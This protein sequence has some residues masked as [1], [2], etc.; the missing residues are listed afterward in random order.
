MNRRKIFNMIG[1]RIILTL[2]FAQS[3]FTLSATH[4]VG[5]DMF[6][7]CLGNDFY[8]V[9]L[10]IRRDC[11]NGADNAQFDDP[12]FVGIFDF[13]GV[14]LSWLG[15]IGN[16]RLPLVSVDTIYPNIATCADVGN[17][18]CVTEGRYVGKVYLPFRAKGYVL[19]YQ[20]CCRNVTLNNILEPLETGTTKFL[21]LMEETLLECNNSPVFQ[22][23]PETIICQD[24]D[25][26]FDHSAIDPDGDSLVYSLYT[27]FAGATRERPRPIPPSGPRY[28]TVHYEQG[29]SLD[30]LLGAG[31]APLNIDSRTGIVTGR[32]AIVGQFL[33]GIKVDEYRRGELLSTTWR[34][35]EYNVRPCGDFEQVSF[36]VDEDNCN[37]LTVSFENTTQQNLSFVWNFNHPSTDPAFRSTE[38]SP[39]FTFPSPGRYQVRLTTATSADD[40]PSELIKTINVFDK[41]PTASFESTASGCVNGIV[42]FNLRAE[43]NEPN[44][45]YEIESYNWTLISG[46]EQKTFSGQNVEASISCSEIVTINLNVKSTTGC[47][48]TITEFIRVD[49]E[50]SL[51]KSDTLRICEGESIALLRE[52]SPDISYTWNPTTDLS[53]T[54]TVNFSDPIASPLATTLYQVT[55]TRG[56]MTESASIL[57][58]VDTKPEVNIGLDSIEICRSGGLIGEVQG[59]D[60]NYSY[61]WS[62]T[63]KVNTASPYSPTNPLISPDVAEFYYLTVT[64]GACVVVDSIFV[65]PIG[66]DPVLVTDA[67]V[68]TE[69]LRVN[70]DGGIEFIVDFNLDELLAQFNIISYNWMVTSSVEMLTSTDRIFS[71]NIKIAESDR[72]IA[73]LTLID[74]FGCE[75]VITKEIFNTDQEPIN[76]DL[77]GDTITICLGDQAALFNSSQPDVKYSWNPSE[78]L[79]FTDNVNFSDPIARPSETTNYVVTGSRDGLSAT[80]SILVIVLDTLT[81]VSI[82][83]LENPTCGTVGTFIG[84]SN[85]AGD[86]LYEW[87]LSPDFNSI[88]A[89]GDSVTVDVGVGGTV[90]LRATGSNG[91]KSS[92]IGF[93]PDQLLHNI[94]DNAPSRIC[95]GDEVD[96]ILS[97]SDG[98]TLTYSWLEAPEIQ[99]ADLATDSIRVLAIGGKDAIEL[100]YIT[101]DSTGCAITHKITIPYSTV[102]EPEPTDMFECGSM[103]IQFGLQ[104]G[105]SPGDVIWNFGVINGDTVISTDIAP[106]ITFDV[107]GFRR[108]TLS[109]DMPTCNFTTFEYGF[110]VPE[111]LTLT[112]PDALDQ[113]ICGDASEPVTLSVESNVRTIIWTDEDGGL[114]GIG[115]SITVVPADNRKVM[116]TATDINDCTETLAFNF[117]D[118]E[119][120]LSINVPTDP[121]CEGEGARLSLED[122][123]NARLTYVWSP[124]SAVISGG[125]TANPVVRPDAGIMTVLVTNEDGGCTMMFDVNVNVPISALAATIE[126]MPGTTIN[127]GQGVT[128]VASAT[129][130]NNGLS[131]LWITGETVATIT[132]SPV[133]TTT[134][135]VT[136]T[137]ANGCTSTAS[138]TINVNPATCDEDGIFV[139]KAFSPNGDGANDVLYVRT[140]AA[141]RM[142]FFVVDRWGKELFRSTDVNFGWNGKHQT[143]GKDVSPDVFAYALKVF[144]IDGQEFTKRGNVMLTR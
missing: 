106:K 38:K 120:D 10:I 108:V 60:D 5:G 84:S 1:M 23:W 67:V 6:F 112:S 53:F 125:N 69:I 44:D 24:Q 85:E 20:R 2:L 102:I 68:I 14:H 122:R 72:V 141:T 61:A 90:Y 99:N 124:A 25:I 109:S 29:Y 18:V 78:G 35:F 37:S 88:V 76:L 139:P 103:T 7:K 89:I 136:I 95:L 115:D 28:D 130:H 64:N 133:V 63:E 116:A 27:P 144:C 111:I 65:T 118:Y 12:A 13:Q 50:T 131:Y 71:G 82:T 32:P 41:S 126:A 100:E 22:D 121:V 104:S 77:V 74:E 16:I 9:E 58:I 113:V 42:T 39:T 92:V 48:T 73:K 46:N 94:T 83:S 79:I 93:K 3:I 34:D 132:K 59:A 97:S 91:C 17:D 30:N 140:N 21:C 47:D 127:Q 56:M 51:I 26:F 49:G 43:A 45:G 138:I 87:S 11:I 98:K 8:E 128:L 101:T 105:F 66:L 55:A 19:A 86:A 117:R 96:I 36:N 129:N 80:D 33:V 114:L 52:S 70:P 143:T 107:P 4:I 54:D 31:G 75:I 40:C 62:P 142:E 110:I 15:S 119:F 81:N 123:T 57:V 134:Y 135:S 137:D